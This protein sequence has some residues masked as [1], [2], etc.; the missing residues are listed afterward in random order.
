MVS[1]NGARGPWKMSTRANVMTITVPPAM[2]FV[3]KSFNSKGITR[4]NQ[5]PLWAKFCHNMYCDIDYCACAC[6][7]NV[8]VHSNFSLTVL[9]VSY[10]LRQLWDIGTRVPWTLHV[11]TTF[12][13]YLRVS[14]M[15]SGRPVVNTIHCRCNV[16]WSPKE[17]GRFMIPLIK[18][19]LV[20][21]WMYMQIRIFDS[22]SE[23]DTLLSIQRSLNALWTL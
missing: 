20:M 1:K 7:W 17:L 15:G 13:I 8:I 6:A 4:N 23:T 18:C 11:H 2:P 14:P 5:K 22:S 9:L 3:A 10:R 19:Y 12:R 16:F 21:Q